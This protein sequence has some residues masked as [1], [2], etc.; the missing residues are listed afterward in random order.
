VNGG[1]CCQRF[2]GVHGC[3]VPEERMRASGR[4]ARLGSKTYGG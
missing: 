1:K 2:G 4:I 3:S